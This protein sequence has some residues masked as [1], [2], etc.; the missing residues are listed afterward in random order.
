MLAWDAGP[1]VARVA[2]IR[3]RSGWP[4][5]RP[6][7][8]QVATKP[9]C[10]RSPLTQRGA[11][12]R[13]DLDGP[14][15]LREGP[16]S[17]GRTSPRHRRRSSS[18]SSAPRTGR[19]PSMSAAPPANV[20]TGLARL[21]TTDFATTFGRDERG[22]DCLAHMK[23]H[24]VD[25]LPRAARRIPLL[26]GRRHPRRVAPR[27]TSSTCTGTS[28]R[29]DPQRR[30]PPPHRVDRRDPG[31]GRHGDRVA[32]C[33]R[34]ARGDDLLRPQLRALDHG[35]RRTR[36]RPHRGDHRAQRCRQGQRATTSPGSIPTCPSRACSRSGETSARPSPWPPWAP[37]RGRLPDPAHRRSL[38]RAGP[39]RPTAAVV[40]TV[41]AGDSF[42]AG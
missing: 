8:A 3:R 29:P 41:G 14:T 17:H 37:R 35:R 22:A 23:A 21:A 39:R 5:R 20:A 36:P 32:P 40:D 6:H 4:Y 24:G 7:R 15:E 13:V 30:Q 18:T 33:A 26:G 9:C 2:H 19:G 10:E 42:M 12:T 11:A 31:A 1:G 38:P 28:P 25:V 34:R 16:A 27:P